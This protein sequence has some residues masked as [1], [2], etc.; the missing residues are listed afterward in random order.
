MK[1]EETDAAKRIQSLYR[2]CQARKEVQQMKAEE[3]DAALRI[4]SLYR[5]FQVAINLL[6]NW[7]AKID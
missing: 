4:Q 1:E 2:G 3:T 5:G 6:S 7:Y